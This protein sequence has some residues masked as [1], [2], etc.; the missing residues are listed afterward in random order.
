MVLRK[1]TSVGLH[2]IEECGECGP[3]GC[4]QSA[5][6]F[7]FQLTC[8]RHYL[9]IKTSACGAEF[10]RHATPVDLVL[11]AKHQ[12]FLEQLIDC[13][14][15][16][17]H[18]HC[19]F[20]RYVLGGEGSVFGQHGNDA[21]ARHGDAPT[22]VVGV[23]QTQAHF[24]GD[25]REAIRKPSMQFQ[26]GE[27]FVTCL[28]G[29]HSRIIIRQSISYEIIATMNMDHTHDVRLRSW[30]PAANADSD[31]PIQNLPHGIFRRA[32]TSEAWRGGVAIGDQILDLQAVIARDLLP[33]EVMDCA[34]KAAAS[35]LNGFMAEPP[36]QRRALRTALSA[37]LAYGALRQDDTESCLVPMALVEMTLPARIENFSDFYSSIHHATNVGALFR[38]DNPV[39][40]NYRWLPV[41]YT[42]R[43][44]S[45]RPSGVALRRP[46]GQ[47]KAPDADV[48]VYT[49]C[50][51]MDYEV[52]LGLLIGQGNELGEPIACGEVDNHLFGV[53]LL[54][55]WSARDIQQWEYQPLG[56]MLSKSF[57]TSLAPWVVTMDALEPFRTGFSRPKG[58]PAP[59]PHLWSDDLP[60]RGSIDIRL[61]LFIETA[62]MRAAGEEPHQI[63]ES[64]FTDAYW[65]M[66]QL[67]AHQTSN[68]CNL[69]PGD[70][71]GSGTLSGVDPFS[72]ACLLELTR[73]GKE[74]I[75][76]PNGEQRSFLND[77]DTVIMR[78]H[79]E[80]A[81][82]VR[83]GL[84]ECRSTLLPVA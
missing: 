2:A 80:R 62:A 18:V 55:D 52:E 8:I 39:L 65:S 41:G 59:L 44:S 42:G 69:Q 53:C 7:V 23:V 50:T 24:I 57:M 67:V 43:T 61:Q 78:G 5:Q 45:I 14:S 16:L 70:L 27:R 58:D 60:T 68:G 76:L 25:P 31:F 54:N 28:R 4:A 82:A 1:A 84:G 51:R 17:N 48:P 3:F 75:V 21:P 81:G 34:R 12:L 13:T 30:I 83:I 64:R 79:C 56:P 73:G 35:T 66:A 22:V 74:P 10:K 37:L 72:R 38:P 6:Q 63:S 46:R 26:L 29:R 32:G 40:P 77:G 9:L 19:C 15:H 20:L 11:A 36:S 47:I 71:L 33:A 49:A